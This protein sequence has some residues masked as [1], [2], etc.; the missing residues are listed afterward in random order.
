MV[1]YLHIRV[2]LFNGRFRCI[3]SMGI[4]IFPPAIIYTYKWTSRGN[5]KNQWHV[6]SHIEMQTQFH[7][8]T[9]QF[10]NRYHQFHHHHDSSTLYRQP[11]QLELSTNFTT[12]CEQSHDLVPILPTSQNKFMTY[13]ALFHK[14]WYIMYKFS[15]VLPMTNSTKISIDKD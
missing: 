3:I 6:A 4:P 7:D 9:N 13:I 14:Q 5:F 15:Y 10:N 2:T 8:F 11:I 12:F 1:H